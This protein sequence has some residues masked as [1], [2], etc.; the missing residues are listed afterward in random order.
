MSGCSS[1]RGLTIPWADLLHSKAVTATA[2]KGTHHNADRSNL[3]QSAESGGS[4]QGTAFWEWFEQGQVAAGAEGF[5]E[6]LYGITTDDP[7]WSTITSTAKVSKDSASL[8]DLGQE[9]AH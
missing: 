6:G 1:G 4:L 2:R 3:L 5:G 9:S 7:V 8:A